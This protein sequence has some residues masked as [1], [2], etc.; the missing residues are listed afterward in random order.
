MNNEYLE[1]F[2]SIERRLEKL[3]DFKKRICKI[4]EPEIKPCPFCGGK[5]ES[6]TVE[7]GDTKGFRVSCCNS[8]CQVGP[9]TAVF[10]TKAE[11][12]AAWNRRAE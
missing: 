8:D 6:D 9:T 1:K 10:P 3:E 2:A 11:A 12:V 5:A 7:D 4:E